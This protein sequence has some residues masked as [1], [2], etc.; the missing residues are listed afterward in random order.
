MARL[1]A[2]AHARIQRGI[3]ADGADLLQ[4]RGPVADQ[5]GPF[6]GVPDHAIAHTVS[7]GAGENEFAVGDIHLPAAKTDRIDAVLEVRDDIT[8]GH[9]TAQHIGVGHARHRGVGI[10]FAAAIAGRGHAHQPGVLPVLHIAY[11]HTVLDQHILGRGRALV[12]NRDRPAPVGEG[13]II[14]HRHAFGGDAL[15]HEA[16]KGA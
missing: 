8:G 3:I 1:A 10:G 12:I 13:A 16:G 7:F 2:V 9:V 14:Q 6:D 11:Q 5:R 4:R 15:A